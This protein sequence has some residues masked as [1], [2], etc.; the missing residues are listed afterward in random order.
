MDDCELVALITAVAC[1]ISQCAS[2]NELSLLAAAFTQLGDTIA[3]ILTNREIV[4][5]MK[6]RKEDCQKASGTKETG[7]ECSDQ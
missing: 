6:N 1:G 2:D 7:P 4:D 5:S 3:T